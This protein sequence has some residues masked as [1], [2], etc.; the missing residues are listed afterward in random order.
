MQ[1]ERLAVTPQEVKQ[2][3]IG[4]ILSGGGST[5]EPNSPESWANM[6]DGFQKGAMSTRLQ[7]PIIYGVDAVHGHNNVKGATIFPHNIGLGATRDTDLVKRIAAVT[8][9][10]IRTTGIHW[11]FAPTLAA[12][13]NI[14]WGRSYEGFS[15]DPKL[16]SKMGAAFV[17]GLQGNPNDPNFLGR[18][19]SVATAK[20]WV[21][22][23]AT[24]DGKDQGNVELTEEELQ[25]FIE[26]YKYAIGAGARTVMVSYS[27]WNGLKTHT[28]HHLVT[29]VLKERL[30]FHGF[31][32]SDWNGVQQTD[33]DFKQAVK[34]GL[35]AGI[36]MF[37]MPYDWE[38]FITTTE[39]LVNSGEVSK[40]RID[41]AV[42]RILRV[43]FED[44][45]FEK[46]YADRGLLKNNSVGSKAHREVAREAVRKS[47]VLSKNEN[48]VLPLSKNDK[49]FVAG[50]KADDIG[51]QCGGWTISW[52]GSSGDIT[53]GTTILEGIRNA[54]KPGATVN[55][56]KNG[57]GAAGHDVAV[58]VVGEEPYAEFEGDRNNL[59]LDKQDLELL[60]NVKSS[61]VPMV[62]ITVSGRPLMISDHIKDWDAFVAAWLP[63]TEGQGVADALFGDYDFTGKL[64]FTWPK[65][66][67][68][69]PMHPGDE[70]YDP[71]FP[72]GYG[73]TLKESHE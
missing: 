56:D 64:S 51:I 49:I 58:V 55:Y 44:R 36:D 12:P 40:E 6:V 21:G 59:D 67:E 10:E 26:P 15:E 11:D 32:V 38:K 50:K 2:Y 73:L 63:G 45:L 71:L 48:R 53:P 39:E 19:K 25:R 47:L 17:E 61:D 27:S 34:K 42:S 31:V 22:D 8:A 46:P 1:A 62:V 29:E 18:T 54:V 24:T 70:E 4:S 30:G 9:K 60:Q 72:F 52:Q 66:F 41:D 13:Q 16:V 43:K 68:Q 23:G 20:H 35:N 33:P 3:K 57:L 14:R 69:I 28:D 37:M 5:P 65:R 7:I